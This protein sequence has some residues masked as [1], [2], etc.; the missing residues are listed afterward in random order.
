MANA[1]QFRPV[2][3]VPTGRQIKVLVKTIT[4]IVFVGIIFEDGTLGIYDF[5]KGRY[6]K[7]EDWFGI[8]GWMQLP[9]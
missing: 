2:A 8:A 9:E 1:T 3:D 4:K 6:I 5:C 7:R